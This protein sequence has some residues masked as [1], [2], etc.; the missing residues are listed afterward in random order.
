MDDTTMDA[1][2]MEVPAEMPAEDMEAA[3]AEM[4]A[5][6]ASEEAV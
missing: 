1:P 5:E 4:P 2:E 3:P 6:E